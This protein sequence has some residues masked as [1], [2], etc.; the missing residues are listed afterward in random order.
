MPGHFP[1]LKPLTLVF[2]VSRLLLLMMLGFVTSEILIGPA[3]N[4]DRVPSAF[5]LAG[6]CCGA[7]LGASVDQWLWGT[8]RRAKTG[9]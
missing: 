3:I 9:G 4:S 8:R 1:Q 2:S 6:A 7:I 5:N